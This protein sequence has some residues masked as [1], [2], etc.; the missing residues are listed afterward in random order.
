MEVE[1]IVIENETDDFIDENDAMEVLNL[2]KL[3]QLLL[4]WR[5]LKW[6]LN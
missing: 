1:P 6:L 3:L 2:E 5:K 4:K